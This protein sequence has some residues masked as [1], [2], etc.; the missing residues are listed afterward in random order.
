M[1]DSKRKLIILLDL[2]GVVFQS[3][4][5]SNDIIDWNVISELND[6][7][8]HELNIGK[9][10]FP[11]FLKEYNQRTHQ[12]ISG[13]TFLKSVF[14]TLQFNEELVSFLRKFGD[15]IIVSDNYR[16]NIDYISQ[17]Y[18]FSNWSVAQVYSFDYEMVK[19]ESGFFSRL[20]IEQNIEEPGN[21]VFID[22]S[23]KKLNRAKAH[24]ISTI[25]FENNTQ[26]KS[27]F[28]KWINKD[29]Y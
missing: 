24:G 20:L 2:G 17:R 6:K 8:G 23:P 14:D 10:L 12:S 27:D 16:E 29:L 9:D 5:I 13:E 11:T 15:I 25:R 28:F 7:Y 21:L 19:S 26:L 4:G 18:N 22:D 1:E 3:T